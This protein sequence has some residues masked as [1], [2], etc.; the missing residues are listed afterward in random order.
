M[1]NLFVL[2]I[3]EQF[4]KYYLP[5]ENTIS[6]FQNDLK[7][8]MEVWKLFTQKKFKCKKIKEKELTSFFRELGK[9]GD[10]NTSLGFSKEFY[11]DAEL[12][13]HLLKMGIKSD[14]GCIYFNELLYRCMRRRYGNMKISKKMQIIE[15][16]TQYKIYQITLREK[17]V[18][19]SKKINNDDIY[20]N[21]VKKGNGVNPFLTVMNFRVSF[22]TWLKF[23]RKRIRQEDLEAKGV[24]IN[25]SDS[26][27]E[28]N[29][30]PY[31][32][33]IEIEKHYSATSEEDEEEEMAKSVVKI[34]KG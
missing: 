11:D 8:F 3:L 26:S 4:S 1:L 18:N 30:K 2:V 21:I 25:S 9:K 14:N 28:E 32:V 34:G 23:A 5:K 12:N 6:L 10:Y 7:A 33:T 20:N 13:K 31:S 29:K 24:E 27:I 16:R 15:L 17:N 19:A 22:K